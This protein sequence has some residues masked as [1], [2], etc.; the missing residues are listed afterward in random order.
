MTKYRFCQPECVDD[1][2]FKYPSI[3]LKVPKRLSVVS[4]MLVTES[5]YFQ[6]FHF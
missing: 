5:L 3:F 1:F 4:L 6:F 2:F